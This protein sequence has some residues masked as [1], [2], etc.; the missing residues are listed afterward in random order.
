MCCCAGLVHL[1]A[2]F[3][4]VDPD[5]TQS[6]QLPGDGALS[7]AAASCQ[8]DHIWQE[9][10]MGRVLAQMKQEIRGCVQDVKK[11]NNAE[12]LLIISH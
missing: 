6:L 4:A 11:K 3:V 8:A 12:S 5:G 7:T 2:Q 1:M 10:E 9:G